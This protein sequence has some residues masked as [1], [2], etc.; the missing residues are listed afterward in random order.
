MD[1]SLEGKLVVAVSSRALFDLE[2]GNRVFEEKG[3]AD[4]IRFQAEHANDRP[5]PGPAFPLIKKLSALRDP[6][7]NENLVEVILVTK[8]DPQT[9]LRAVNLLEQYGLNNIRRA[10]FTGGQ[11]PAEFLGVIQPDLFLSVDGNDVRQ[12]LSVGYA[13]AAL[14]PGAP[15]L[16]EASPTVR[17]AFDGDAVL[18]S[19]QSERASQ[20]G[21]RSGR[22]A[23]L[24]FNRIEH[25]NRDLPLPPGPFQPLLASLNA[26]QQ[27]FAGLPEKPLEVVL[28]TARSLPSHARAVKTLES[29]GL[30]TDKGFFLGGLDKGPA[31]AQL[32]ADI[33]FDDAPWNCISASLHRVTA[34]HVIS[35]VNNE[36][37][38][39]HSDIAAARQPGQPDLMAQ[40]RRERTQ[41]LHDDVVRTRSVQAEPQTRRE[42]AQSRLVRQRTDKDQR[43]SR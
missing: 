30:K 11:S 5:G 25:D 35:G 36:P 22:E 4:Y 39:A 21:G 24:E 13:S 41:R 12:A 19:D 16:G 9:G 23:V 15:S 14:K 3:V 37:G 10:A 18:F 6:R 42:R 17:I 2:D 33:L 31:V 7:T 28:V 43:L 32:K 34:G 1:N 40:L 8:N 38:P 20:L 27:K 29:W 26:M